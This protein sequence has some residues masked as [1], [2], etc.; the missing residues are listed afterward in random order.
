MVERMARKCM[1][2]AWVLSAKNRSMREKHMSQECCAVEAKVM[3]FLL[4]VVSRKKGCCAS[5]MMM[6]PSRLHC[7]LL[8]SKRP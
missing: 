8:D 5:E 2:A 1:V 7:L 4:E 3:A 6:K